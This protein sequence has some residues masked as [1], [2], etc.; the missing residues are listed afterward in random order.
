MRK[1]TKLMPYYEFNMTQAEVAKAIGESRAMVAII[2]NQAKAKA[3]KL[4][5]ERGLK[6]EDLVGSM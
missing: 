2:E 1:V 5:A 3:I 4:L 6:F